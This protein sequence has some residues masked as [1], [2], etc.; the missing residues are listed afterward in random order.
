[1]DKEYHLYL[2][3]PEDWNIDP[4]GFMFIYCLTVKEVENC[5]KQGRN[6]I[7][8]FQ[9]CTLSTD[10]F[11]KGYRIFIHD[12][13]KSVFEITLGHCDRT[14]KDIRMTHNLEKMLLNGAFQLNKNPFDAD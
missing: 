4:L 10:L 8:T 14:D 11:K 12:A 7:Y 1:M 2:Y 5:I 3:I 6:K 9:V 13:P